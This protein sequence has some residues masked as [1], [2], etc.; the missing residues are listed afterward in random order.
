[1]PGPLR[2]GLAGGDGVDGRRDVLDPVVGKLHGI[3]GEQVLPAILRRALLLP[4]RDVDADRAIRE[5]L[6]CP[7]L[8]RGQHCDRADFAIAQRLE[9]LRLLAE[10][11]LLLANLG[12]RESCVCPRCVALRSPRCVAPWDKASGACWALSTPGCKCLRHKHL[13]PVAAHACG[14]PTR[15]RKRA[16]GPP[17][18]VRRGV[19]TRVFKKFS[20]PVM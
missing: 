18:G 4:K 7:S 16:R 10:S 3:G 11:L 1:M 20:T 13:A 19:V 14:A 2:L 8:L 15:A 9:G 17:V 5:R 6:A 12:E